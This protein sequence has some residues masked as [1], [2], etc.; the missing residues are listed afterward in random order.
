MQKGQQQAFFDVQK[1]D[2]DPVARATNGYR[3]AIN[4]TARDDP[5]TVVVVSFW[6][7]EQALDASYKAIFPSA[8]KDLEK[9][10]KSPPQVKNLKVQS[11]E[12]LF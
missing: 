5:D 6:E 2:A 8:Q 10:L 1:K 7:D 9:S 11:A 4:F 12:I 3:G